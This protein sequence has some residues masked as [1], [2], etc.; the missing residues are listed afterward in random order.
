MSSLKKNTLATALVVGLGLTG[1]AAAYNYGT[2]KDPGNSGYTDAAEANPTADMI[3][4][5]PVAYQNITVSSGYDYT[6]R[7]QLVWDFNPPDN[8]VNYTQGF[9]ARMT[10]QDGALFDTSYT[11]S[12]YNSSCTASG[13]VVTAY[14][15]QDIRLDPSLTCTWDVAFDNYYDGGKTIS[16]RVTPKQGITNPQNPSSGMLLRY[17]NAR[18][19]SLNEF[20][21]GP[22]DNIVHGQFWFIN[23]SND[24]PFSGSIQVKDVLRKVSGV[25][26]CANSEGAETDKY[27]DVADNFLE[28]QLPKTRFSWDGKLGSAEDADGGSVFSPSDYNSQVIDLG[29]VVLDTNDSIGGFTFDA[30]DDFHTVLTGD[31]G[32][33]LA[34]DNGDPALYNDDVYL[35]NG[36]CSS[37]TIVAQGEVSGSTVYFDYT[38]QDL[39]DS[40]GGVLG[41]ENASVSMTVCGFVDTDTVINDQNIHVTTTFTRADIV[42]GPQVF[43]GEGCNLLPLRYNGSTM[44]IFTINP[45]SNTSQRSFIRLTNRSET[46]GYVSLEGI[47]DDGERGDS[48]VRIWIPAGQSIQVNASE[49]ESGEFDGLTAAGAWGEAG[50]GMKWRAVV[51]AEFPGL[52]ATSLMNSANAR[53]V[54]NVTD[55]DTRGEQHHRDWQEG[56]FSSDPGERQSDFDQE[57][58]PDFQGNGSESDEPGGPNLDDGPTGGTTGANGNPGLD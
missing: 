31:A 26:A 29:N 51:T 57:F 4:A 36:S 10:L 52:V 13:A 46:D 42:G 25:D 34:F 8:A 2:L 23:P 40:F 30:A 3:A 11:P 16:I 12:V 43:D 22:I 33:W 1:A 48:Q 45:G 53:V 6:M 17:D 54:T 50:E 21:N 24:A 28:S 7:E 9:T 32:G 15:G 55:S 41:N 35:V 37:G 39:E 27:I 44:E 5:E 18:L 58:S 47:R 14:A 19:T 38:G 56:T 20:V 49:L